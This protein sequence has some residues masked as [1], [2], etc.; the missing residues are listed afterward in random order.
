M[1]LQ[2]LDTQWLVISSTCSRLKSASVKRLDNLRDEIETSSAD[3]LA[4]DEISESYPLTELEHEISEM[5]H[6]GL[7]LK[8]E[9]DRHESRI[10]FNEERCANSRRKNTKGWQT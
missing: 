7:E 1:E 10:Q 8:G 5:Q 9:S 6:R 3:V 2:H 4:E